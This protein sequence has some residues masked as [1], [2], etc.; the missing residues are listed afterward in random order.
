MAT[1][2]ENESLGL[3][4]F[5]PL[6]MLYGWAHAV[7]GEVDRKMGAK[8]NAEAVGS[9][10]WGADVAAALV[11]IF[12]RSLD[13][14]FTGEKFERFCIARHKLMRF[15][16]RDIMM[17][18][19]VENPTGVDWRLATID[20]IYSERLRAGP[21]SEA[22]KQLRFDVTQPFMWEWKTYKDNEISEYLQESYEKKLSRFCIPSNDQYPNIDHWISLVSLDGQVV[23]IAHQNKWSAD[24]SMTKVNIKVVDAT[25]QAAIDD[26]ARKHS[27]PKGSIV[28][29][30][31]L[32]RVT[33]LTG[34]SEKET[35][36]APSAVN[37]AIIQS[38]REMEMQLGPTLS[39]LL[40]IA[41]L[42]KP[43]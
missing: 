6:L 23:I 13:G 34:V 35:V 27:I 38:R 18:G 3:M 42:L 9:S 2:T 17:D 25:L 36:P 8:F 29:I 7:L 33:G 22:L 15:V 21:M 10:I 11:D 12:S 20:D 1:L 41:E 5:S 28:A 26:T 39:A 40:K 16:Y 24:A 30:A 37:N 32:W 31:E 43:F 19:I 4:P 14:G